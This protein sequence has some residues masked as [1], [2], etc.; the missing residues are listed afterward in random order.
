V[1]SSTDTLEFNPGRT[2]GSTLDPTNPYAGFDNT[3]VYTEV[4]LGENINQRL[5]GGVRFIG[6]ALQLGAEVSLSNQGSI[7]VL[8]TQT[9]QTRSRALP[10]I[11][12]FNTT[13]GL[14]F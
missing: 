1:A 5:Y 2:P 3:G 13:L 9:Q 7:D 12:A 11:F 4:K 6:G 14:D 8:N 10:A